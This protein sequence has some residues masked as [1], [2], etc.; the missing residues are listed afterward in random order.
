M[1]VVVKQFHACVSSAH[2]KTLWNILL[3]VWGAKSNAIEY[4]FIDLHWIE[5]IKRVW[6]HELFNECCKLLFK[7][8]SFRLKLPQVFL[9]CDVYWIK[10]IGMKK[11]KIKSEFDAQFIYDIMGIL[12]TIVTPHFYRVLFVKCFI[13]VRRCKVQSVAKS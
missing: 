4:R 13:L 7:L 3:I 9:D 8:I 12:D 2:G 10:R 1:Q 11:I 5:A 6:T